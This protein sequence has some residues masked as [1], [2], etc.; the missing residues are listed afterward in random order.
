[1]FYSGPP[2]DPVSSCQPLCKRVAFPLTAL[3][4][5]FLQPH[6][7]RPLKI[8]TPLKTTQN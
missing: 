3:V 2:S 6:R 8:S 5:P 7:C 4:K 1:M